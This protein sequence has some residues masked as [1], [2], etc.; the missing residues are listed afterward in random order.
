MDIVMREPEAR[1][2]RDLCVRWR[3]RKASGVS[4][5]ESGVL[6]TRGTDGIGP[7]LRPKA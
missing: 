4:Q 2:S 7:H 3:L 5:C 6:R 1:K